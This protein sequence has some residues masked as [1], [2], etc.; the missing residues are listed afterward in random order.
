MPDFLSVMEPVV[1]IS[2]ELGGEES[3]TII[4]V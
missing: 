2:E 4:M 1:Q 3:I